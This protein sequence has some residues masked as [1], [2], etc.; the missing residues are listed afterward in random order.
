M[1][2]LNDLPAELITPICGNLDHANIVSLRHTSRALATGSADGFRD[3]SLDSITVTCTKA[4]LERLEFLMTINAPAYVNVPERVNQIKHVT[5]NV[6]TPSRLKELADTCDD[7]KEN[8]Y[9]LAYT[10]VRTT[11]I[12]ALYK[13]PN[14]E[15]ITIMNETFNGVTEPPFV[16]NDPRFDTIR[17][18]DRK[19]NGDRLAPRC[20]GFESALSILSNYEGTS[21]KTPALHSPPALLYL[22]VDYANVRKCRSRSRAPPGSSQ[23][24]IEPLRHSLLSSLPIE[25]IDVHPKQEGSAPFWF[26][27]GMVVYERDTN[28]HV[29][30]P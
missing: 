8:T 30:R 12:N 26:A 11:L 18:H 17:E 3:A 23:L 6:L 7:S 27:R 2:S 16:D 19:V 5:I 29:R 14:L 24:C 4:G 1:P 20:Y 10:K 25:S 22:V 13:L 15:S 21:F 28:S 9:L